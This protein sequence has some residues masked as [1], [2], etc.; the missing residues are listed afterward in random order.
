MLSN[1]AMPTAATAECFAGEITR[2]DQ[3]RS[4]AEACRR[5]AARWMRPEAKA[6]WHDL[7]EDFLQLAQAATESGRRHQ[8]RTEH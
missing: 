5:L 2:A 6:I 1:F 4:E 7:A 3:F 8:R